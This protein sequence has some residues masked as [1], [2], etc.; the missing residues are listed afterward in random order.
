MAVGAFMGF[1]DCSGFM[2]VAGTVKH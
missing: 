2:S 1:L